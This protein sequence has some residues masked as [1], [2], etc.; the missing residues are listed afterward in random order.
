MLTL[1]IRV[2]A[3]AARTMLAGV[4]DGRLRVRVT[5]PPADGAANGQVCKL[6]A[7]SFGAAASRVDI[8]RGRTSRNKSVR[9]TSPTRWPSAG[10]PGGAP[11]LPE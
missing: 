8:V 11:D 1:E 4:A 6:L 5:A 2:Q 7:K 3:R 10:A 9:I